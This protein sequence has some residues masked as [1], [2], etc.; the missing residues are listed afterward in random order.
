MRDS[1][2]AKRLN[3]A[4]DRVVLNAEREKMGRYVVNLLVP[5]VQKLIREELRAA[6]T[7]R[8]ASE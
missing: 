7:K 8:G 6:K 2:I 3:G 1:E 4:L 5:E